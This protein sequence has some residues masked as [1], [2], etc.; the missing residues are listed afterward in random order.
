MEEKREELEVGK[1]EGTQEWRLVYIPAI[2]A[3]T[4]T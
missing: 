3:H 2:H 1:G 4:Y